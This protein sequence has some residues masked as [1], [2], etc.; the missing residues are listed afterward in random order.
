M[1]SPEAFK[2]VSR[3]NGR[4]TPEEYNRILD[5]SLVVAEEYVCLPQPGAGLRFRLVSPGEFSKL[6]SRH[7]D[8]V[9]REANGVS[10]LTGFSETGSVSCS[11]HAVVSQWLID[12][13][14][15]HCDQDQ[16]HFRF[17]ELVADV[18]GPGFG[19]RG[20]A[21]QIG[22]NIYFG[23]RASDQSSPTPAEGPGQARFSQYYRDY[24]A[25]PLIRTHLEK[26]LKRL[27]KS[28]K[29]F[30]GRINF[31]MDRFLPKD[32][33]AC[34][35]W[36][37]GVTGSVFG[38]VNSR[39]VDVSDRLGHEYEM[40][41]MASARDMCQGIASNYTQG[42]L[43]YLSECARIVGLGYSTT[44]AYQHVF[45]PKAEKDNIQVLQFFVMPGL[46]CCVPILHNVGHDFF[47]Y[48]FSHYTSC[49]VVIQ[50]GY[51]F[52]RS[53]GCVNVVAWGN[54]ERARQQRNRARQGF[55]AVPPPDPPGSDDGGVSSDDE[56][57]RKT[58]SETDESEPSEVE[59]PSNLYTVLRFEDLDE[60]A[61]QILRRRAMNRTSFG[62]VR[63]Q[64]EY[65]VL[66]LEVVTVD[67]FW[68]TYQ[69]LLRTEFAEV[70]VS[71]LNVQGSSHEVAKT[72][73]LDVETAPQR[74][75]TTRVLDV[76]IAPQRKQTA[77]KSVTKVGSIT[78]PKSDQVNLGGVGDGVM[79]GLDLEL[80]ETDKQQVEKAPSHQQ[81][82][83]IDTS[84]E[85]GSTEKNV[86]KVLPKKSR[87]SK[88]VTAK[89]KNAKT[90][91]NNGPEYVHALRDVGTVFDVPGT[92]NCGFYSLL[93]ALEDQ[94]EPS[95]MDHLG[96]RRQMRQAATEL[97]ESLFVAGATET[98]FGEVDEDT[99][100]ETFE[101]V[102]ADIYDDTVP[103]EDEDFML[104]RPPNNPDAPPVNNHHWM[105]CN[106]CRSS[107]CASISD[108][109]GCLYAGDSR[110]YR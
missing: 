32:D 62:H 91:Y 86:A 46:G 95:S 16:I 77:R 37:Q 102:A 106:Y 28:V 85:E 81:G 80:K 103:Y 108:E 10:M 47:A 69:E 51:V 55:A 63:G 105:R 39:H 13:Q 97:R 76:E 94:N 48:A 43:S 73:V 34:A 53:N 82:D 26:T 23:Y 59:E 35:L 36:T 71:E 18:Y 75:Q 107:I 84:D 68:N 83:L 54:W 104:E 40:Y 78:K 74:K 70:T 56:E 11:P 31:L 5:T 1:L 98:I 87:R 19:D 30:C 42:V 88:T 9:Q 45:H 22:T 17:T 79:P 96:L 15:L 100:Q 21:S 24:Y 33:G 14:E 4:L 109:G 3:T 20:R 27:T 72:R 110:C 64:Y 52:W 29:T 67:Q 58:E 66:E 7:K 38:Y 6:R 65:M 60:V 8:L 90:P 50:D 99:R 101:D 57:P 25:Y 93:L 44:C 61:I 49:C 92:G 12:E 89:K 2:L 41:L